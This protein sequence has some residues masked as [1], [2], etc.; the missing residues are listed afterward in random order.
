MSDA[1]QRLRLAWHALD[2]MY[3]LQHLRLLEVSHSNNWYAHWKGAVNLSRRIAS[4]HCAVFLVIS[5]HSWS[6]IHYL[7]CRGCDAF[8]SDSDLL[9]DRL[10]LYVKRLMKM[11]L[12]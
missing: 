10:N 6:G 8:M 7:F 9:T 3:M 11:E 12:D 5:A 1:C 2:P 4:V